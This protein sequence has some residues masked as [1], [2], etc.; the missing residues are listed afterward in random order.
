MSSTHDSE[1]V[2][3]TPPASCFQFLF[4]KVAKHGLSSLVAKAIILL[5]S[6][7]N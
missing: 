7:Q 5:S 1:F 6:T 2:K 4:G 3:N